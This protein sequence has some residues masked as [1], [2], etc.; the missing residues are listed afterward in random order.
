M[1]TIENIHKLKGC[2]VGANG[3]VW[4]I[5]RTKEFDY[6]SENIYSIV[7]T[8]YPDNIHRIH[9]Y[10]ERE[11]KDGDYHIHSSLRKGIKKAVE[12]Q[13]MVDVYNFLRLIKKEIERGLC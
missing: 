10:L 1:L 12:R 6:N 9:L 2:K 7:L 5:L 3:M 8:T 13:D 11:L 4:K